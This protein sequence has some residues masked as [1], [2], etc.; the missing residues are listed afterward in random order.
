MGRVGKKI[1]LNENL[2]KSGVRFADD[3]S[4]IA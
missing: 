4:E 2:L 1:K 3:I